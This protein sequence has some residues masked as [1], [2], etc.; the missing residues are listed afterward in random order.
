MSDKGMSTAVGDEGGFAPNVP[1]HEAAIQMILDAIEFIKGN[2]SLPV[3][4]LGYGYVD[5]RPQSPDYYGDKTIYHHGE[6]VAAK[7]YG[8][9][10]S[11]FGAYPTWEVDQADWA[12][13]YQM[14]DGQCVCVSKVFLNPI[15]DDLPF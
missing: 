2:T 3:P 4:F 15:D 7:H 8:V 14:I 9:Y 13:L 11:V 5:C 12:Y 6:W 1:G 10:C